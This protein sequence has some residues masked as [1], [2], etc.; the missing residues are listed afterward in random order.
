MTMT[1]TTKK[2]QT[3][4]GVALV[5]GAA[6]L[7]GTTGTAQSL[8]PARMPSEWVGALRLLV[9]A[10]FFLPV[11]FTGMRRQPAGA[12]G[13]PAPMPWLA[14]GGAALC[15]CSYNLSFFAGVR[16]AGV[17]AGTAVAIGSGPV[18]AGLMQA[19]VTRRSPSLRWWA[20]AGVAVS[21]VVLLSMGG[22]SHAGPVSASG[23]ALCLLAGLSYAIYVLLN[24]RMVTRA[25]PEVTTST[26]FVLA[27]ALALPG[28]FLLAGAPQVQT[29]SLAV[30]LWLGVM[31]T[32]VAYW[33][34]S[35]ALR[36]LSASTGVVL[37]LA[38]PVVAFGLAVAIVGERPG[39]LGLLGLA[40]VLLGLVM[41]VRG[42]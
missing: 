38:E 9:A 23:L 32:G 4:R 26:V 12:D 8:V 10:V 25:S 41:V 17:A 18:W 15:M 21:G 24:R 2:T 36:H 7:W 40:A 39:V 29:Q 31:S 1:S 37:S 20:G 28:A 42:E 16:L 34:F 27:A 11:W 22:P 5:L 6:A 3:M 19:V 33:L 14:V 13:R 35:H 30:V